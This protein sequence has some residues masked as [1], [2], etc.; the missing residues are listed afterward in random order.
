MPA[1]NIKSCI[2]VFLYLAVGSLLRTRIALPALRRGVPQKRA[3]TMSENAPRAP[4]VT[5]QPLRARSGRLP[6]MV[7]AAPGRATLPQ[8]A[9]LPAGIR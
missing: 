3:A 8:T 7:P 1:R 2:A 6:L 9:R 5:E 4:I